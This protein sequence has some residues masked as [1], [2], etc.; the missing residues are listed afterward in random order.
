[1]E[2]TTKSI[3]ID[4]GTLYV[5]RGESRYKLA[6]CKARVEVCKS[7]SKLPIIG[8][9]KVD[10]RFWSRSII[11]QAILMSGYR[12]CSLGARPCGKTGLSK[13]CFLI[14]AC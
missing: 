8:G 1:M 10:R 6:D 5:V 14:A 11:W 4:N 3:F 13:S 2:K 9:T 12:W 7:V